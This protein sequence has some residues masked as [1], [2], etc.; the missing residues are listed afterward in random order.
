MWV[1]PSK[2]SVFR[3]LAPLV[4]ECICVCLLFRYSR[5]YL[6][7]SWVYQSFNIQLSKWIVK[8]TAFLKFFV[9]FQVTWTLRYV[10]TQ[11]LLLL[12]HGPECVF[13]CILKTVERSCRPQC[14][15]MGSRLTLSALTSTVTFSIAINAPRPLYCSSCALFWCAHVSVL[16]V[17]RHGISWYSLASPPLVTPYPAIPFPP[18]MV[19]CLLPPPRKPRQLLYTTQLTAPR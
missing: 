9:N 7:S 19:K 11:S 1:H 5:N 4:H 13:S 15:W 6:A 2:C 16:Y 3:L 17:C 10:H 8:P 18:C 12:S 14:W